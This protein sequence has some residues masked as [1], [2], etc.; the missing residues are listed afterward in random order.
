MS[1]GKRSIYSDLER[2]LKGFPVDEF[3]RAYAKAYLEA[4]LE[5]IQK[6]QEIILGPDAQHRDDT[7]SN[8]PDSLLNA[9]KKPG[10]HLNSGAV[11]LPE[12]KD[13]DA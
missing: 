12:P 6:L 3:V 1:E 13:L 5:T 4:D 11:A 10:P 8:G 2:V 9:P 7:D